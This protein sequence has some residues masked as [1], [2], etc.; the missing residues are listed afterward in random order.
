MRYAAEYVLPLRASGT[1]SARA[2]AHC[3]RGLVQWIDVTVV[4]GSAG[5]G[6]VLE[7][8]GGADLVRPQN[9]FAPAPW[10]ARWDTGR[11]LLD[12]AFASD[13]PGTLGVRRS[14][15]LGAVGY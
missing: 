11:I 10:H 15:L 2:L 7:L 12:R 6:S 9:Y 3:L 5:P 4:D 13:Y 8:L 14:T 1:G